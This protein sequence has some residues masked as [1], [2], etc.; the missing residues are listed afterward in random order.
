MLRIARISTLGLLVAAA[1]SGCSD[2]LS[3][4]STLDASGSV[5]ARSSSVGTMTGTWTGTIGGGIASATL[6]QV[7]SRISGSLDLTALDGT[8]TSFAAE[9]LE[10]KGKVYVNLF[11][12]VH[13]PQPI[14][15]TVSGTSFSGTFNGSVA[16]SLSKP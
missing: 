16:V 4:P 11:D 1:V 7:G 14:V 8:T 2:S 3:S 10:N 6:V 9:G 13:L 15:G 12:G 5:A